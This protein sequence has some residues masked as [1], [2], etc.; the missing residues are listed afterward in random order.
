M[1]ETDLTT[2]RKRPGFGSTDS[3]P[4]PTA[5]Q[6][7][8]KTKDT[9]PTNQMSNQSPLS[10][11]HQTLQAPITPLT[12]VPQYPQ[13]FPQMAFHGA[14][15]PSPQSSTPHQ[16]MIS[17][18]DVQRIASAVKCMLVSEM[19][20]MIE[21]LKNQIS[22]LQRENELLK[23]ELDNLEMYSRRDCIRISGV[24]EEKE[25][26]DE[27]VLEIADKLSI[28]LQQSDITVSHRVGPTSSNKPR[29]II[30]RIKNYDLKHQL[31]KSSKDLR[32]ISGME[33]VAVNQDLTKTR[34]KLAYD[35]RQLVK[36]NKAKSTFIWD[37]KIFVID[38]NNSKHKILS[39]TD[40]NKLL[41]HL[42]IHPGPHDSVPCG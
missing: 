25:N 36:N 17:D 38:N 33:R 24:S 29:Q 41:I 3:E 22:T 30:A 40:M 37:G 31:L 32:K 21:P 1:P 14:Y 8:K 7:P 16:V 13:Q 11:P 26:T 5:F 9:N 15:Q 23:N 42:G 2:K 20:N 35:A 34:N 6:V 10:D 39:P 12:Q 27:A 18:L 28:P 4:S 19:H